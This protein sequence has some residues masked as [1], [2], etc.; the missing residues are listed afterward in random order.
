M[1]NAATYK[2]PW[3]RPHS[4]EYGP[5]AFTTT[6]KPMPHGGY[7]IY[8]RLP[9]VFDVVRNGVCVMQCAGINGAKGRIDAKRARRAA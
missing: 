3:H 2:N 7:L 9:N 6:V 5:A 8:H 1:M 4:S